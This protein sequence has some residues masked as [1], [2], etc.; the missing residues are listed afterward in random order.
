MYFREPLL[1]TLALLHDKA[2]FDLPTDFRPLI[3]GCYGEKPLPES[4]VPA[5]ELDAARSKRKDK[6]REFTQKALIHLVPDPDPE[7]FKYAQSEDVVD[8]AE[9]G[10]RASYFRAQ[11]R[12]PHVRGGEP[13]SGRLPSTACSR[14]SGALASSRTRRW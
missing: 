10:D 8:E 1:R 4:I 3:E 5:E 12:L 6:E 11:T 9:E 2:A 13:E 7:V 14:S